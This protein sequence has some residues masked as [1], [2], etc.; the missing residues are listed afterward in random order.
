MIGS[1]LASVFW[2]QVSG[3]R[4]MFQS[5]VSKIFPDLD[6]LTFVVSFVVSLVVWSFPFDKARD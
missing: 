6:S 5:W 1:A 2:F 3:V 4:K